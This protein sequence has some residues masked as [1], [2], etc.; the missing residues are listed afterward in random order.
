MKENNKI[1]KYINKSFF[2]INL[3]DITIFYYG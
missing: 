1:I 3:F 2:R